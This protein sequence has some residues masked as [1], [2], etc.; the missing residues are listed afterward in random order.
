MPRESAYLRAAM[1]NPN[2]T[3]RFTKHARVEM[4]NDNISASDATRV[5]THGSVR[6]MEQK[7]EEVWHVEGQDIDGRSIRL[8]VVVYKDDAAV[9]IV[10]A[11]TL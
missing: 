3:I 8:V 5:L 9:K 4:G 11:M 10:T 1:K 6:H 7:Q 2:R